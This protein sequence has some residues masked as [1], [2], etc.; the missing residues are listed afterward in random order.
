MANPV[1]NPNPQELLRCSQ[2]C[3][4]EQQYCRPAG[5]MLKGA[6]DEEF[7]RT[8]NN[9]S[10]SE[11][12]SIS[13]R[14]KMRLAE[15]G[16]P[17]YLNTSQNQSKTREWL[18]LQC[19]GI[20]MTQLTPFRV[21][22][23]K[24]LAPFLDPKMRGL[25]NN[26]ESKCLIK[27]FTRESLI[28]ELIDCFNSLGSFEDSLKVQGRNSEIFY[29]NGVESLDRLESM[30]VSCVELI[31]SLSS[32]Y[33]IVLK[34]K[35][36]VRDK[37]GLFPLLLCPLYQ[38]AQK[39]ELTVSLLKLSKEAIDS[40][41]SS[42]DSYQ[43]YISTSQSKALKSLDRK[44]KKEVKE[45]FE[46][47]DQHLV[48]YSRSLKKPFSQLLECVALLDGN[49]SHPGL[50][51][52]IGKIRKIQE[53][54]SRSIDI[55]HEIKSRYDSILKSSKDVSTLFQRAELKGSE[56]MRSCEAAHDCFDHYIKDPF[57][58]YQY[59]LV[60]GVHLKYLN[61]EIV[62]KLYKDL[63]EELELDQ[64]SSGWVRNSDIL[65]FNLFRQIVAIDISS[66]DSASQI[67][68]FS[69][70]L[71]CNRAHAASEKE[72]NHPRT[73]FMNNIRAM[74]KFLGGVQISNENKSS[75]E[76]LKIILERIIQVYGKSSA[77]GN[78]FEMLHLSSGDNLDQ[79]KEDLLFFNHALLI[80]EAFAKQMGDGAEDLNRRI[81]K[82]K[83]FMDFQIFKHFNNINFF[84]ASVVNG[85]IHLFY[86]QKQSKNMNDVCVIVRS[87]VNW[88][89]MT[90]KMDIDQFQ[91]DMRGPLNLIEDEALK[92]EA[93][94]ILTS[95]LNIFESMQ[96]MIETLFRPTLACT[97]GLL[98]QEDYVA[99]LRAPSLEASKLEEA[100]SDWVES[101]QFDQ[102]SSQSLL[103][104]PTIDH[105]FKYLLFSRE[106]QFHQPHLQNYR[107]NMI[108]RLTAIRE[109]FSSG[110]L[111]EPSFAQA[112]TLYCETALVIEQALKSILRLD[113]EQNLSVDLSISH[114]LL[115]ILDA[116]IKSYPK[117]Q[118]LVAARGRWLL[119]NISDLSQ[120][121]RYLSRGIALG[122]E[123]RQILDSADGVGPFCHKAREEVLEGLNLTVDLL[124]LAMGTQKL[125][126]S[127][128]ISSPLPNSNP[129][130][131]QEFQMQKG[132]RFVS[133]LK[134]SQRALVTCHTM[135][136]GAVCLMS[137]SN[138][139][140]K[141]RERQVTDSLNNM[142]A[143]LRALS[144]LFP[145]ACA[146]HSG[147]GTL[148]ALM[149][150]S[151]LLLEQTLLAT[152]AYLDIPGAIP[153]SH[154][155]FEM[156]HADSRPRPLSFDHSVGV[157]LD[158]LIKASPQG[159]PLDDSDRLAVDEVNSFIKITSRYL[160][161]AKGDLADKMRSLQELTH[162]LQ[163]VQTNTLTPEDD[164]RLL[165]RFQ[166]LDGVEGKL[167]E[168]ILMFKPSIVDFVQRL[169]EISHRLMAYNV[170]LRFPK[171]GGSKP[172]Q[173]SWDEK[174]F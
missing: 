53:V 26:L 129:V 165:E 61:Y 92:A 70:Y 117:L 110:M 58:L 35:E 21:L 95:F 91:E 173:D 11:K 19:Q 27:V 152:I 148:N 78:L 145:R 57:M 113:N 128:R 37:T 67:N 131:L 34:L 46:K 103:K 48:S 102:P 170:D 6:T 139:Q 24:M 29:E 65:F 160:E 94:D 7:A 71:Y 154:I 141:A 104:F 107:N 59:A 112:Q 84:N 150:Q 99:P 76:R 15:M 5:H 97:R 79:E 134:R 51:Y 115:K 20:F 77:N 149:L 80:A 130:V 133:E 137:G 105:N 31:P 60:E 116:V 166:D 122:S 119:S 156:V 135:S 96:S 162:L 87:I 41:Q 172:K 88:I 108:S 93:E 49:M 66:Q 2:E 168:E 18:N 22:R 43:R 25:L 14:I 75:V 33:D 98:I 23:I 1:S 143:Y 138:H 74:I 83:P 50:A 90:K 4:R 42:V 64:I 144:D 63:F 40:F 126:S 111:L 158:I 153:T 164:R 13:I 121:G 30:L 39:I 44:S 56:A 127:D 161:S 114:D 140:Q 109:E 155:L 28:D 125:N 72:L 54:F 3:T 142:D 123:F 106:S 73:N 167:V 136:G 47:F 159:I 85:L 52:S 100:A 157:L 151:T 81:V 17:K 124:L 120:S 8:T 12:A 101:I 171:L 62:G 16:Y 36:I 118:T 86:P 132:L 163:G 9:L 45:G 38:T 174:T 69:I 10:S 146:S 32:V 147:Y 68:I 89:E 169:L 82:I 55:F